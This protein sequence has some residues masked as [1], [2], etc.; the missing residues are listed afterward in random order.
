MAWSWSFVPTRLLRDPRF[1]RLGELDSALLLRLYAC[2]DRHGRG[3]TDEYAL[4]VVAGLIVGAPDLPTRVGRLVQSTLLLLSED[5][6]A[7]QIDRYDEDAPRD[8]K[9][10]RPDSEYP[11]GLQNGPRGKS[12]SPRGIPAESREVPGESPRSAEFTRSCACAGAG[13]DET[14][15]DETRREESEPRAP[16]RPPAPAPG[17]APAPAHPRARVQEPPDP[18]SP[19]PAPTDPRIAQ[20]IRLWL[21]HLAVVAPT[22]CIADEVVASVA[23]DYEP[24]FFVAG[25]EAHIGDEAKWWQRAPIGALRKR[26]EWAKTP[27]E[28]PRQL[29]P[30]ALP[31]PPTPASQPPEK[32]RLV[33]PRPDGTSLVLRA[34]PVLVARVAEGHATEA[35]RK[36]LK[37]AKFSYLNADGYP[38]PQTRGNPCPFT[39]APA[40]LQAEFL[41]RCREAQ[42]SA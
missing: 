11:E 3:P 20:A 5:G 15:R 24:E 30:A 33:L 13:G 31:P 42:V 19:A 12:A 9:R 22:Q 37:S 7:W 14:R 28:T 23:R 35:E 36:E 27:R 41:E 2:C 6:E 25:V 10:D 32:P 1:L 4:R 38:L 29:G 8:V 34:D 18:P 26:C 16:A 40:E 21:G 17:G 39:Y